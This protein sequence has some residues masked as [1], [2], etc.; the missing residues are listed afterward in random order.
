MA[1]SLRSLAGFCMGKFKK[2]SPESIFI[3]YHYSLHGKIHDIIIMSVFH[4]A[5]NGRK[6]IEAMIFN[7]TIVLQGWVGGLTS[8]SLTFIIFNIPTI[9]SFSF[10]K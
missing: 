5:T 1:R 6:T 2:I 3:Y 9:L 10:K 7:K 4:F 8:I